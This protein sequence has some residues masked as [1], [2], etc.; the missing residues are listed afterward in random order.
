MNV[1]DYTKSELVGVLET[2]EASSQS[3]NEADLRQL[4]ISA[5]DLVGADHSICA[6]GKVSSNGLS[7]VLT[8]INGDYP[9]EWIGIYK[10]ERLHKAD[11]VVRHHTRFCG[12]QLWTDTF[13]RYTDAD[14][15]HFMNRAGDF[16]LNYGISSGVYIPG[17]EMVSIFS[18]GGSRDV[19]GPHHKRIV[20]IVT[21][22][23]HK[24]FV[25]TFRINL[26]AE[27]GLPN[28]YLKKH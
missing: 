5:K 15:K 11:P 3:S 26:Q 25:R 22:H 12:T 9:E 20:D 10:S 13:C 27:V 17:E 1:K 21:L 6:M 23:L 28:I 8:V 24:A 19:F 16:G 14:A 7:D 2:V 18:F 4:I